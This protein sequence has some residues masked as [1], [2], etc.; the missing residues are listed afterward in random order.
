VS[1]FGAFQSKFGCHPDRFKV[2]GVE[3]STGSLGHGI[4]LATGMALAFRLQGAARQAF[5]LVGDGESN[6]GSVW[7]TVMVANNLGLNNLTILYDHNQSQRRS[8]QIPNPAER[9]QAF[10][11]DTLEVDGH[12]Y[13][14]IKAALTRPSSGVKAIVCRTVKGYGCQT[15]ID[16]VYEW[17]RKSPNQEQL[18]LLLGELD[19][20]TV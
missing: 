7:E 8:L 10:G 4:G 11:C 1:K 18:E 16:N 6:E 2:P 19:A 15:L 13:P 14:A 12:D 9:L 5:T 17:H 3:V 20:Q